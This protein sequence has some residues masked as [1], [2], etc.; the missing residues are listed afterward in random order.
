VVEHL[1]LQKI[2]GEDTLAWIAGVDLVLPGG[3]GSGAGLANG[4]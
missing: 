2:T 4:T 3:N 1:D